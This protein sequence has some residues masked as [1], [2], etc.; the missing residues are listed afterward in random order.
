ME[1]FYKSISAAHRPGALILSF[2]VIAQPCCLITIIEKGAYTAATHTR[3]RLSRVSL[4]LVSLLVTTICRDGRSSAAQS[5]N[6][7]P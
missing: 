2:S 5:F 3:H 1:T 7:W 6:G 4:P